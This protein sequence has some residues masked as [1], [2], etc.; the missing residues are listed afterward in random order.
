MSGEYRFGPAPAGSVP[1]RKVDGQVHCVP[2]PGVN[3]D[4]GIAFDRDRGHR[5]YFH[6]ADTP[7]FK[8]TWGHKSLRRWAESI[9]PKAEDHRRWKIIC[10]QQCD[11]AREMD[12]RW[13]AAG[14]P[15]EGVPEPKLTEQ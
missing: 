9:D 14:R 2:K 1:F 15:P 11:L 4:Y 12:E 8:N 13:E 6:Y 10:L 5:V 7:Q 3:I